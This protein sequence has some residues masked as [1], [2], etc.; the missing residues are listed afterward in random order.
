MGW[1]INCDGKQLDETFGFYWGVAKNG[2]YAVKGYTYTG[3]PPTTQL[4]V[5]VDFTEGVLMNG[6][7]AIGMHSLKAEA[8]DDSLNG[9]SV[10]FRAYVME[11]PNLNF[12]GVPPGW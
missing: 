6:S 3:D 2:K 7:M 11:L 1:E 12:V 5:L 4:L 10:K 8:S 9:A